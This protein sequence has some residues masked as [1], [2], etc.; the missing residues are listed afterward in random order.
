MGIKFGVVDN[1]GRHY[2]N[3]SDKHLQNYLTRLQG[4]SFYV[5][6]QAEGRDWFNVFSKDLLAQCDF[7]IADERGIGGRP[8]GEHITDQRVD[9]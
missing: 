6:I 3:Y 5:G 1:F 9:I 2:W 4:K 7:I 8:S